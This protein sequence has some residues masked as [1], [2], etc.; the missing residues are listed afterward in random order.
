[1]KHYR[2]E[3]IQEWCD[4]NGW[5]DLF[6]ECYMYWAFPPGAVM[7][8]P[9]PVKT[10][11]GIKSQKGLSFEE[12]SWAIATVIGTTFAAILS[13]YLMSPIPL[14]LGFSLCA[15]AV[16]QLEMEEL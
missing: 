2:D 7:P 15:I 10:L 6:T 12:K 11:R 1:M 13:Y 16:V 5:T 4:S 14:M 9:I 8:E 3:W